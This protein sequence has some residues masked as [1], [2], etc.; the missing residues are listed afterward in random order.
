MQ[1]EV[2]DFGGFAW[3][4]PKCGEHNTNYEW[5]REPTCYDC[6]HAIHVRVIVADNAS[7]DRDGWAFHVLANCHSSYSLAACAAALFLAEFYTGDEEAW[8]QALHDNLNGLTGFQAS[9]AKAMA[10]EIRDW[11]RHDG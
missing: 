3:L 11:A 5:L 4:C 8:D 10:R 7:W 2:D 9:A 6:G 1:W